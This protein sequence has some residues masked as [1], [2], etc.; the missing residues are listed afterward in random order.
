MSRDRGHF[1]AVICWR[2]KNSQVE[3]L[4]V[5]RLDQEGNPYSF[6]FPG[7]SQEFNESIRETAVRELK[8][9]TGI[10]AIRNRLTGVKKYSSSKDSHRK[11]FFVSDPSDYGGIIHPPKLDKDIGFGAWRP[12]FSVYRKLIPWHKQAAKDLVRAKVKEGNE[13]FIAL[14]CEIDNLVI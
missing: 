6:G 12:F 4:V 10:T 9:E 13:H 11:C 7:G 5:P 1:A 2:I 8:E 3:V 14:S